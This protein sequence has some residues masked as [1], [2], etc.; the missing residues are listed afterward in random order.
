MTSDFSH[1]WFHLSHFYNG[2][3]LSVWLGNFLPEFF[4]SLLNCMP[5]VLKTC[6]HAD[7]PC[8]LACNGCQRVL[9][10]YVL[11]CQHVLHAHV[12][13]WQC[14]L[15]A[16][17]FTCSSANVSCVLTCSR[18]KA[19]YVLT[20]SRANLLCV[21]SCS[22]VSM[23]SVLIYS[24]VNVACELMCSHTNMSWVSC[25]KGLAWPRDHLPTCSASSGS[26]FDA[27]FF[28]FNAILVEVVHTVGKG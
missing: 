9:R 19:P 22:H 28:C 2:C 23:S 12:L 3:F 5:C 21:L 15:C 11:T 20:C 14:P 6:S 8:V 10:A 7:V 24:R 4:K 13:T 18:D 16:Y 27:T 25:L 1:W 17:V 26:S